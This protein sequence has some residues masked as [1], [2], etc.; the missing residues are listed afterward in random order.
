MTANA[1]MRH[2]MGL[3]GPV[4]K[5][6]NA[7]AKEFMEQVREAQIQNVRTALAMGKEYTDA[8]RAFE[9]V[10]LKFDL[11][12]RAVKAMFDDRSVN[13]IYVDTRFH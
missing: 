2:I 13:D 3:P 7:R 11:Q 4:N 12:D 1:Y 5:E 6:E 8:K 10:F 9:E